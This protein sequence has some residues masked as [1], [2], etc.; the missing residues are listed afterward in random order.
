MT[1][2]TEGTLGGFERVR[3][4][5]C[6]FCRFLKSPTIEWWMQNFS[7]RIIRNGARSLCVW[8]WLL[9][10]LWLVYYRD[11]VHWSRRL[12]C[13]LQTSK[14]FSHKNGMS[15]AT[16][17]G[18]HR[19]RSV[20]ASVIYLFVIRL[21]RRPSS[22][23]TE[24]GE[25]N[26]HVDGERCCNRSVPSCP[27]LE[28]RLHHVR[29]YQSSITQHKSSHRHRLA[30]ELPRGGGANASELLKDNPSQTRMVEKADWAFN[31]VWPQHLANSGC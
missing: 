16:Y 6:S 31:E 25:G 1:L 20:R 24:V 3:F 13:D 29:V 18:Q 10:R 5:F 9:A 12:W 19:R 7:I 4:Y 28:R 26:C 11:V 30:L 15:Y 23:E 14:H 21:C 27:V 17:N 22:S 2:L 8:C